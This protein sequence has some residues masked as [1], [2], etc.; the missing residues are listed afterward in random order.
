VLRPGE[1]LIH[2]GNAHEFVD[3]GD[4][5]AGKVHGLAPR[6][7]TRHP[8]GSMAGAPRATTP[9][10]PR[11]EWSD[12]IKEL[13][14]RKAM[15]SD[16]R[17][18][19]DNGQRIPSRDQNGR[20]YCWA[21]STVSAAILGR[22][23]AGLPYADLSAYAI[24]CII[25]GY[26]DQGGWNGESMDFLRTR[27]CPTSKTWAQQSVSRSNDNPNTWAEAAMFK[28]TEYEDIE[29]GDFDQQM[30]FALLG[31]PCPLDLNWWSHSI[32]GCDPVDGQRSFGVMRSSSGK[33][34]TQNEFDIIW[35]VND[36]GAAFGLRIWNSW[37]DDWSD[38]GMGVLTESKATN[39]GS[40][41][42]K[43]MMASA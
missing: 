15:L 30:T 4:Q 41:A 17:D 14:A 35:R 3:G 13:V 43:V 19:G 36:Y 34:V 12:R 29:E 8:C 22:A 28:D 37:G 31:I 23:K 33:L 11:S 16:I 24:A 7:W 20:G 32:C 27:G 1:I 42:L 10:I 26:R 9:K 5:A 2:D 40:I 18:Q 6:D 25:K 39:N 21:H 38:A